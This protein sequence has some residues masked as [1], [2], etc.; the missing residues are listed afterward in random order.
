MT[1]QI[2]NAIEELYSSCSEQPTPKTGVWLTDELRKPLRDL[3]RRD[4]S[5]Y[6][7]DDL[8]LY[9]T[10]KS[11]FIYL[12]PRLL[13]LG[14]AADEQDDSS[15]DIELVFSKLGASEANWRGWPDRQ[16]NAFLDF[17][18]AV[19]ASFGLVE[20]DG[21]EIDSW[22]IGFAMCYDDVIPM[23]KMYFGN[24]P[25]SLNNLARFHDCNK[26]ALQK[27]Q[28]KNPFIEREN[29]NYYYLIDWFLSPETQNRV[30][31]ARKR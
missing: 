13:E 2:R 27:R 5:E 9:S 15:Y 30:K 6:I 19:F 24:T 28:L 7:H 18:G 14:F 12:F 1:T 17:T 29:P 4:V 11:E 10:L 16:R 25:I 26:N 8:G 23:L 21:D 20:L 31:L 22:V 3:S